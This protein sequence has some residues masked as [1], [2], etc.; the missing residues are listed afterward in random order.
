M[1]AVNE[2]IHEKI[3][4]GQQGLAITENY[5]EHRYNFVCQKSAAV[6]PN[7]WT[8]RR[9][10]NTSLSI[11]DSTTDVPVVAVKGTSSSSTLCMCNGA[12]EM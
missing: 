11:T 10:R 6:Y 5:L 7:K 12:L 4:L 2:T 3:I 8:T 1:S 9:E